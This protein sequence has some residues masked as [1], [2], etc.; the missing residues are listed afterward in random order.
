[1]KPFLSASIT[2]IV[3][4]LGACTRPADVSR[5]AVDLSDTNAKIEVKDAP[6]GFTVDVR[7]SR[8]Q[9]IP[10]TGAL[11]VACRSL[12]T[13]RATA[14]A[15]LRNREIE[16]VTDESIRVSAGRNIVNGRTACRAFVEVRWKR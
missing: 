16:P 9:F 1:M 2:L 14:E 15:K 5:P 8:Y 3:L 6:S 11:I 10:E 7:Y 4:A 13:A 12:A